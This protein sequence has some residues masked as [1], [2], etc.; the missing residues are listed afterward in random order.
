MSDLSKGQY[1]SERFTLTRRVGHGG[2]SEVWLI[3][4]QP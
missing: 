1:L 2:M 4:R 3:D